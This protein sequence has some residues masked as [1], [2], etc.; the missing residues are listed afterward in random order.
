MH[1]ISNRDEIFP[2]NTAAVPKVGVADATLDA[3]SPARELS[4]LLSRAGALAASLGISLDAWMKDAWNSYVD[5][6]PGLR[7]H[8]EDMQLLAQLNQLRQSGR[9]SQA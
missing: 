4:A 2:N 1:Q 5:A 6:Q 8:I 9:I 3:P 7:E